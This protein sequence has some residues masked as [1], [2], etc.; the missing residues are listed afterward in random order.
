M[1]VFSS[2]GEQVARVKSTLAGGVRTSDL[3]TLGMLA[4]HIPDGRI[5]EAISA[6][7]RQSQ[8]ERLLPAQMV[9]L[10]V[11]ALSVFRDVS[12]EEVLSCVLEGFRWL[13]LE[14]PA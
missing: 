13:G 5:G 3:V 10:Y 12:Y 6:A 2:G 1:N 8:R 4:E 14:M 9:V 11:V 7:G